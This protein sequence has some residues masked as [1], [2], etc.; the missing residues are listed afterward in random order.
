MALGS[1]TVNC[2]FCETRSQMLRCHH[3]TLFGLLKDETAVRKAL[4]DERAS[5]AMIM[6][7]GTYAVL[8]EV[9]IGLPL[10][11][12]WRA[13]SALVARR[14]GVKVCSDGGCDANAIRHRWVSF[15]T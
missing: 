2:H 14:T 4:E 6:A 12:Q 11:E 8:R 3:K 1:M 5:Y 13:I 7:D 10:Q 15:T 9:L